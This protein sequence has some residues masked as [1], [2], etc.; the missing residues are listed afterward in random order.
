MKNAGKFKV[1]LFCLASICEELLKFQN[2]KNNAEKNRKLTAAMAYTV[3]RIIKV[4]F[5]F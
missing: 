3:L 5:F 1:E 2:R 4:S